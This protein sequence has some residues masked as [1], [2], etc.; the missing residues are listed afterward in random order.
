MILPFIIF[1][2]LRPGLSPKEFVA[3]SVHLAVYA[4]SKGKGGSPPGRGE[5]VHPALFAG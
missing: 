2:P 3:E 4:R 5:I 1:S